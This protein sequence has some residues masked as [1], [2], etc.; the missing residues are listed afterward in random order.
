M[1]ISLRT[2]GDVTRFISKSNSVDYDVTL[3][4]DTYVING[5]SILGIYSLDLEKPVELIVPEGK[6][7]DFEE[8]LVK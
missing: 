8:F 1:K 3:T 4:S 2:I 6:E 5:K 7:K